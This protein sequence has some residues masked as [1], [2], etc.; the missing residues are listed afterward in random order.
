MLRNL[1]LHFNHRLHHY[2]YKRATRSYWKGPVGF[3]SPVLYANPWALNDIKK[4]WNRGCRT[5]GFR[6]V[7]GLGMYRTQL[8]E[9]EVVV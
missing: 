8:W 3:I 5:S 2:A 7:T 1:H 6:A 9:F 4:G